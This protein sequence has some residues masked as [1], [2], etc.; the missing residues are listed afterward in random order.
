MDSEKS[1]PQILRM[2]RDTPMCWN[3]IPQILDRVYRF[4]ENMDTETYP[5]D[6]VDLVRGWFTF[7]DPR[8]GLW[9]VHNDQYIVGHLLATPEPWNADKWKYCLIRQAEIDQGV[10]L[11][12]ECAPIFSQVEAWT[13]GMGLS[14]I[15]ILTH[16]NEDAMA[17][18]WKFRPYKALMV[19]EI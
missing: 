10:D 19:K 15:I 1:S 11:R 8:L 2:H 6:A 14:K 3:F 18:K 12:H 4:C 17:R 16:R 7:A 5:H 9:I 13:K